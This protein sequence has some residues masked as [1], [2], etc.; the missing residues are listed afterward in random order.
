MKEGK[1]LFETFTVHENVLY[2]TEY[3]FNAVFSYNLLTDQMRLIAV[4]EAEK[5]EGKRLFGE[6][7]Y[8]KDCLYL[9]PFMAKNMYKIDLANKNTVSICVKQS[10][11]KC[12][13]GLSCCAFSSAHLY[14]DSIYMFSSLT[15]TVMEYKIYSGEIVYYDNWWNEND[16]I[17]CENEKAFFRK[18]YIHQN[19]IYAPLCKTNAVLIMNITDKLINVIKIGSR[20]NGF[21]GICFDGNVFWLSPRR[22]G[23][24]T[25][26]DEKD[27]EIQT[28]AIEN[29]NVLDS[30]NVVSN[31]KN[32]LLLPLCDT[33]VH[34]LTE[35][36]I[37]E[38]D[39]VGKSCYFAAVKCEEKIYLFNG[40]EG[41]LYFI[42]KE[43]VWFKE[44]Y[45]PLE[46]ARKFARYLSS[47]CFAL[48]L[49]MPIEVINEGY[50]NNLGEF[51]RYI[52][53]YK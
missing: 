43:I 27:G 22:N 50:C 3:R 53:E 40:S 18:T 38:V 16:Y 48:L 7:I 28:Y 31:G 11:V 52:E 42:D 10:E 29:E 32:T 37:K 51:I 21:S 23:M 19:C 34:A 24:I 45:Y 25:R 2:F 36:Q 35:G 12:A 47:F 15:P 9:I 13:K 6:I 30:A 4:L 44:L 33:Y 39:S 17:L 46:L 1:V 41:R 20:N 49:G 26:W 8:D 14:D 5:D